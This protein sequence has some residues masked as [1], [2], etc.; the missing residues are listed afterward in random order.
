MFTAELTETEW[1]ILTCI[2]GDGKVRGFENALR[3]DVSATDP[4]AVKDAF[5]ES[6]SSAGWLLVDPETKESFL[7]EDMEFLL[8]VV[9]SPMSS[10]TCR[11]KENGGFLWGCYFRN[12]TIVVIDTLEGEKKYRMSW[13][14]TIPYV[15]GAVY[16][17]IKQWFA[18]PGPQSG[19]EAGAAEERV[20]RC[21][22]QAED[23]SEVLDW[24]AQEDG[25]FL[26]RQEGSGAFPGTQSGSWEGVMSGSFKEVF[27]SVAL[28]IVKAHGNCM[29]GMIEND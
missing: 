6:G 12:D 17:K 13:V 2:V 4:Q 1:Q 21:G 26:L 23:N 20:L 27:D 22:F 15:L 14:P 8:R 9:S 5:L 16:R 28:W 3:P 24:A 29:R 18:A 25:S 7:R 19:Q 11:E 10:F